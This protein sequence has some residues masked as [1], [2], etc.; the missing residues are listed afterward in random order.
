MF[1]MAIRY[2]EI[3]S[4]DQFEY[5]MVKLPIEAGEKINTDKLMSIR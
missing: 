2:G 3:Y 4:D 1:K 5:V